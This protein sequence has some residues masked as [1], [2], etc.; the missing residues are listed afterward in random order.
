MPT[1]TNRNAVVDD[2]YIQPGNLFRLMSPQQ[3]QGL[4]NNIAGS[5]MKAPKEIQEKMIA[6]FRKA[7]PAYGDGIA[8]NLGLA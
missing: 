7:D 5:L 1:D 4:I 3:Q 6:H 8:K 2:D